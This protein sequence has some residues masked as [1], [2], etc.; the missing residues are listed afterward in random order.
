MLS[1]R[2]WLDL[3]LDRSLHLGV[4]CGDSKTCGA[5]D[6]PPRHEAADAHDIKAP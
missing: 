4:L 6:H 1:S 3:D 2:I 5:R